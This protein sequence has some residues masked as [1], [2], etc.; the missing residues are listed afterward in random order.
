MTEKGVAPFY[1][2][3]IVG[4]RTHHITDQALQL[5]RSGQLL[6]WY[7]GSCLIYRIA[8]GLEVLVYYRQMSIERLCYSI[9]HC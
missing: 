6:V 3:Y 4:V 1:S 8:V 5:Y 7:P 9:V 2:C